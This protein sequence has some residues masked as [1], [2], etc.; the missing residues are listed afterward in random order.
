MKRY[1]RPGAIAILQRFRMVPWI[2]SGLYL[3]FIFVPFKSSIISDS[4]VINEDKVG[5]EYSGGKGGSEF[6]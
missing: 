2:P 1:D 3:S 4:L 6:A 5:I